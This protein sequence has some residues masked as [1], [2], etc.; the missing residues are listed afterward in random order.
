MAF[1]STRSGDAEVWIANA[2]G[3]NQ[4]RLT[5]MKA[6]VTGWPTWSSDGS[7][8]LFDSNPNGTYQLYVIS[9]AGGEPTQLTT[10]SSTNGVAGWSRD[11]RR[12]YFISNRSGSSEI[13]TMP[14][15]TDPAHTARQVTRGG[16][17]L[18]RESPDGLYYVYVKGG[19]N[20]PLCRVPVN[21]GDEVCTGLTISRFKFAPATDGVYY[22]SERVNAQQTEVYFH[23]WTTG[24][25]RLVRTL[26]FVSTNAGLDISPDGR[27]LLF[28][29][30][31]QSEGD[32]MTVQ[33][34]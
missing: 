24:K 26:P 6:S 34:P 5:T 15:A 27:T 21:G 30:W 2:D 7:R 1:I 32:L 19:N 25:V 29:A 12:I 17:S 20:G 33:L 13:W 14:A 3:T 23:S 28:S 9:S 16:A 31:E 22:L 11:G 10:G 8:I 18:A 4:T